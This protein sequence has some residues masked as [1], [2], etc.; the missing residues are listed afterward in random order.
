MA[1]H[2]TL[3]GSDLHE[4]KGVAS[5]SAGTVAVA[6]GSGTAPWAK[7]STSNIDSSFKNTNNILL[8]GSVPD[9]S[10]NTS[11]YFVPV[12]F[13]C[14]ITGFLCVLN[15]GITSADGVLILSN[16]GIGVMA[17]LT[18]PH[19]GSTAGTT[20]T[21]AISS[22]NAVAAGNYVSVSAATGSTGTCI[23]YFILYG[24][25]T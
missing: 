21:S 13:N 17:T 3:T 12:P 19:A 16:P 1:L 18:I 20:F 9:L 24:T 22:N 10:T 6:S 15:N 8:T 11:H 14:T 5:A 4:S 23:V 7:I 25:M 2:S